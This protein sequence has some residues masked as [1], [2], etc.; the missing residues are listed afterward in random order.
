MSVTTITKKTVDGFV[1]NFDGKVPRGKGKPSSCFVT[2][3]EGCESSGQILQMAHY[4]S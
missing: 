1:P 4:N 3:V 2:M